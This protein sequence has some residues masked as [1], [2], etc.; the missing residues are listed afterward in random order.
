MQAAARQAQRR[1]RHSAGGSAYSSH[2]GQM[3]AHASSSY[4]DDSALGE[5]VDEYGSPNT[6]YDHYDSQTGEYMS[7]Q[8]SRKASQQMYQPSQSQMMPGMNSQYMDDN[9]YAAGGMGMPPMMRHGT[10]S[11]TDSLGSNMSNGGRDMGI[12]NLINRGV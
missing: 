5:D 6:D 11:H 10:H 2:D 1:M 3:E 12:Q 9:R 7:Q 4:T 8:H